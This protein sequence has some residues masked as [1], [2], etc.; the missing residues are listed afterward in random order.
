SHIRASLA[1][2]VQSTNSLV[3][4]IKTSLGLVANGKAVHDQNH[5]H[6]AITYSREVE[7]D[8]FPRG[9]ERYPSAPQSW[10][11]YVDRRL[12]G[13]SSTDTYPRS[14]PTMPLTPNYSAPRYPI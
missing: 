13:L 2:T 4:S 10:K 6:D 14:I 3:T 11:T 7:V 1:A 8:Q 5:N 9:H 12:N